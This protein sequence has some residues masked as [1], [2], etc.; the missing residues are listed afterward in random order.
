MNVN[1]AVPVTLN[2]LARPLN[3]VDSQTKKLDVLASQLH[4]LEIERKQAENF[5]INAGNIMQIVIFVVLVAFF[6]FLNIK[7]ISLIEKAHGEDE[8]LMKEFLQKSFSIIAVTDALSPKP[9]EDPKNLTD[10]LAKLTP[11]AR[12][13]ARDAAKPQ[14]VE[15]LSWPLRVISDSVI[16]SLITALLFQVGGAIAVIVGYLY[17][18][19]SSTP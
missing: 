8:A 1:P 12:Q 2:D 18:Q 9:S 16:T 14:A 6:A 7:V 3:V 15:R 13:M 10:A 4:V 5:R 11:E 19:P 17:R